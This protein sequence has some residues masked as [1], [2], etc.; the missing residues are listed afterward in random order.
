MAGMTGHPTRRRIVGAIALGATGVPIDHRTSHAEE[1]NRAPSQQLPGT[2]VLF[3]QAVEGPYYFDPKLVRTDITEGRPGL[4]LRLLLKFIDNKSCAP[5][6]G[7]RV[8]VWH[9]DAGGIYSG[10][11]GQGDARNLTTEGQH[12]LRG[13]QTTDAQGLVTFQTIYPG[14]YPGRTP[15]IHLKTFLDKTTVLTGQIYFPDD[16]SA[17]VY[18]SHAPYSARPVPDTTN[19]RDFI[20][21]EGEKDG[22]GIILAMEEGDAGA[23]GTLL[24]GV[25]RSGEAARKAGGIWRRL[26]GRQ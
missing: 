22:G 8:D 24:I 6:V 25:D 7:A 3:P 14:W 12:Y 17:R 9:C 13:T 11:A 2:C 26:F 5:I 21:R 1:A 10:Y 15:H 19:M 16:M 20:F 18:R 23:I 4:P